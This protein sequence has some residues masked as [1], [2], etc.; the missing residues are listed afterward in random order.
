MTHRHRPVAGRGAAAA[1][2][3]GA[4]ASAPGSG[5]PPTTSWTRSPSHRCCWR[6]PSSGQSWPA[7]GRPIRSAGCSWRRGWASHS[8][9]RPTPMPR[10]RPGRSGRTAVGRMGRLARCDP[11]RAGFSV[12]AG[13]PAVPRRAAAVT[14]VAGGRLADRGGGGARGAHGGHVFGGPAGP[15]CGR[16][17][18]PGPADTGQPGRPSD[19][20]PADRVR[21]TDPGGGGGPGCA[22][23]AGRPLMCGIRSSGSPTPACSPVSRC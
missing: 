23:T 13:D 1:D 17:R 4:G 20:R 6:S 21:T 9:S 10:T 22:S 15:G 12:R 16:A 8:A 11:R 19:Q 3:R 5:W 18:L 7:T 14:P 2:R